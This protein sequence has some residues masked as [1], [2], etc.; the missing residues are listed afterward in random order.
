MIFRNSHTQDR[1]N[2]E[3]FDEN[4]QPKCVTALPHDRRRVLQAGHQRTKG[5]RPLC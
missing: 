3:W 2:A 1:S 4:V 5:R